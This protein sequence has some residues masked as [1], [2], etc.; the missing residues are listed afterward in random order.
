MTSGETDEIGENNRDEECADESFDGLLR[1]ELDE[2]M[3]SK[4]HSCIA[5]RR[6]SK[7][8]RKSRSLRGEE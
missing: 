4:E 2:L 8:K 5:T 3:S 7:M 1:A 6:I